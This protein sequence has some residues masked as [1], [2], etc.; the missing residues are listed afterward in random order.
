[1]NNHTYIVMNELFSYGKLIEYRII[2]GFSN[3]PDAETYIKDVE[4]HCKKTED[5]RKKEIEM[6]H[7][8]KLIEYDKQYSHKLRIVDVV[9]ES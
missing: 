2:K 5:L 8:E 4:Y 9:L 7:N 3:K 6:T 1:M